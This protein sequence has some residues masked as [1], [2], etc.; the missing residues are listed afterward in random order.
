M[1]KLR[2]QKQSV[3]LY[4]SLSQVIGIIFY[5]GKI[6]YSPLGAL[7]FLKMPVKKK[8]CLRKDGA[9]HNPPSVLFLTRVKIWFINNQTLNSGEALEIEIY[10]VG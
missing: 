6:S 4:G 5:M 10:L 8:K 9:K 2:N 7:S 3:F 1:C